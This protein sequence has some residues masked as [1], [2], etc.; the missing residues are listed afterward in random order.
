[1]YYAEDLHFDA[2]LATHYCG[3]AAAWQ[4]PPEHLL[5]LLSSV[6]SRSMLMRVWIA[7]RLLFA[8]V[9][10]KRKTFSDYIVTSVEQL[11]GDENSRDFC[12]E[13]PL[14]DVGI[15]TCLFV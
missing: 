5:G 4:H 15:D 7:L 6:R 8:G 10:G 13:A 11:V 1:M 3:V 2:A 9:L 14:P 12:L